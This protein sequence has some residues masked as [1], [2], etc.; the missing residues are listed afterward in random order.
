MRLA[1]ASFSMLLLVACY[2]TPKPDCGFVC[3]PAGACPADYTCSSTDN[4]CHRN[5]A[6]A[7]LVCTGV[8]GGPADA[9]FDGSAIDAQPDAPMIDAAIDAHPDAPIDAAIDAP[10]DAPMIDA[11]PV[12]P[13]LTPTTDGTAAAQALVVAEF[14][15]GPT[16]SLTLYNNTAAAIILGTS[17]YAIES[18]ADQV[19]LSTLAAG[20]TINAKQYLTLTWT[21]TGATLAGGEVALFD[22]ITIATDY[23]IA[24]NIIDYLCWGTTNQVDLTLATT[25]PP[26]PTKFTGSCNAAITAGKSIHRLASKP[27]TTAADYDVTTAPAKLTCTAP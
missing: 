19:P 15:P 6:A 12:C 5:G 11:A 4:R 1:L 27:G 3:G 25:S 9:P 17:K 21:T 23:M 8:D 16:G 7:D 13:A 22:N 20:M 26:T 18:G 2:K 14:V 24:A 10:I